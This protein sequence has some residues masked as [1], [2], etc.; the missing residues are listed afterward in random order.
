[1]NISERRFIQ[2]H[3]VQP[4]HFIYEQRVGKPHRLLFVVAAAQTVSGMLGGD[5]CKLSV[6]LPTGQLDTVVF[7]QGANVLAWVG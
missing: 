4:G 2:P 6:L 7:S 5:V 1:M 3:E